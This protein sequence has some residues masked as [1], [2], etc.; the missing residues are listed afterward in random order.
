MDDISLQERFRG[1]IHDLAGG[2]R[3]AWDRAVDALNTP[4]APSFTPAGP[5]RTRRDP[6]GIEELGRFAERQEPA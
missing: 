2:V 6:A 5:I 3:F 1:R 4:A